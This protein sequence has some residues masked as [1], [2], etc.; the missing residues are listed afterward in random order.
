[1][2]RQTRPEPGSR[3][4]QNSIFAEPNSPMAAGLFAYC[5]LLKKQNEQAKQLAEKYQDNQI[6][7]IVL[8]KIALADRNPD[9]AAENLKTAIAQRPQ[10]PRGGSCQ[11]AARR[12]WPVLYGPAGWRSGTFGLKKQ[13]K[14]TVCP[15][16]CHPLTRFSLLNLTSE[17]QGSATRKILVRH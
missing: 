15:R 7:Q 12:T 4:G 13:L 17:A 5:L 8:A 11:K 6:A 1:M 3:V 2:F 14:K 16:I 9:K 10:R